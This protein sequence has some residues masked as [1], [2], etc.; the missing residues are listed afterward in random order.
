[1][2]KLN[3]APRDRGERESGAN[4]HIYMVSHIYLNKFTGN[5]FAVAIIAK[6]KE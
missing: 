1:M 3:E 4:L 6:P 2:H 5:S